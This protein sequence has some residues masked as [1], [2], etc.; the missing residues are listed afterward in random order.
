[1]RTRYGHGLPAPH[2]PSTSRPSFS[3]TFPWLLF[4]QPKGGDKKSKKKAMDKLERNIKEG[5]ISVC[6]WGRVL[7]FSQ[8]PP[9]LLVEPSPPSSIFLVQGVKLLKST[10]S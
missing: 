4:Q 1:M 2:P 3:L 8:N 7:C 5:K 10:S 6:G 9:P